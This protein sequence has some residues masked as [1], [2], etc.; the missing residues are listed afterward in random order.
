MLST[1]LATV[2]VVIF[3]YVTF[4]F[5][6][7][8]VLRRNDVAD[9]AWGPGIALVGVTA[10]L[11]APD[12]GIHLHLLTALGLIWGVRLGVHIGL[13]N[14]RKKEDA[15]YAAWRREWGRWFLPRSYLQ[16]FVLQGFLMMVI[17]Y[18]FV[19]ASVFGGEKGVSAALIIGTLIWLVGFSF[20]T[21]GD[22]QLAQ[23]LKNPENRG[24]IMTRG[25]WRYTRHPNYFG[26]VALWWGI[27]IA[28]LGIPYGF[29]AILSPIA[30]TILI[31]GVSGIPMLE[32]S[33]RDNPD[34][35]AYKRR[36]S[37]FFPLPRRAKQK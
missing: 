28:L 22:Y 35:E 2:G 27:F 24:R 11:L 20:E 13:R 19:H 26:E 10:F 37:A 30:I 33:F 32:R 5:L 16:V 21:I 18:P 8:L 31:L 1:T 14:A 3:C 15:R 23:F 36:T 17:G 12:P 9:V 4:W 25:L 34:F 7:S 29:V 6:C